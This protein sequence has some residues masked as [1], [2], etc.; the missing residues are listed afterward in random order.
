MHVIVADNS[1]TDD[2]VEY[3]REHYPNIQLLA[4]P[5]NRGCAGGAQVGL[6]PARSEYA[7][8]LN[9]DLALVSDHL[10]ILR[11]SGD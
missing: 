2:T 5:E 8:I 1:S 7:I 6:Q 10:D 4:L 3:L 9:P 11:K